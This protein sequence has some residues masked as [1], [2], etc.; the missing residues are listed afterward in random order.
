[1]RGK[2]H[3]SHQK[4]THSDNL[5]T[6]AWNQNT[7]DAYAGNSDEATS[8]LVVNANNFKALNINFNQ[9]WGLNFS[10]PQAVAVT[11]NGDKAVFD[12]CLFTSYQDTLFV[13]MKDV[14]SRRL[15]ALMTH[16][17]NL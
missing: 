11:V 2:T 7:G 12:Q 9:T 5:V 15:C 16:F 4:T 13:G 17:C 14:L 1:M 10:G 3:G 6:I 8:A